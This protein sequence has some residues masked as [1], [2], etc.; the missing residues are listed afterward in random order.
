MVELLLIAILV[1]LVLIYVQQKNSVKEIDSYFAAIDLSLRQALASISSEE[2]ERNSEHHEQVMK[3]L[4][5][6]SSQSDKTANILDKVHNPKSVEEQ[7]WE[8]ERK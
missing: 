1:V 3:E 5:K 6:I 7:F 2:Q 8:S 4:E